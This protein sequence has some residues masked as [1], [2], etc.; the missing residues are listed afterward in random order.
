MV[1]L[2]LQKGA[3]TIQSSKQP[4]LLEERVLTRHQATIIGL[5][6]GMAITHDLAGVWGQPSQMVSSFTSSFTKRKPFP[7]LSP[8]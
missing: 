1:F 3:S 5:P 4:Q 6:A 2:F 8:G 7:I